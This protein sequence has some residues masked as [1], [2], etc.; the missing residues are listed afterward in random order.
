MAAVGGGGVRGADP[1][2]HPDANRLHYHR[3]SHV[4]HHN[5]PPSMQR[6]RRSVSLSPSFTLLLTSA[7]SLQ[8]GGN[9][10]E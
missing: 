4:T 2:P 3:N 9:G 6:R 7:F 8:C 1:G 5:N 10:G